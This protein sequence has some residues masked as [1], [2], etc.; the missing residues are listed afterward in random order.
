MR[1]KTE[2]LSFPTDPLAAIRELQHLNSGASHAPDEDSSEPGSATAL[3]V[4]GATGSKPGS[5][6]AKLSSS[7]RRGPAAGTAGASPADQ[8]AE[9]NPM[10]QAVLDM[11]ARPYGPEALKG[12]YTVTT[13]KIPTDIWDRLGMVCIL[14]GQTK[15]DIIAMALRDHFARLLEQY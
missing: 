12:P 1:K 11:L 13:M 15:Q 4:A 5:K 9:A 10:H 14:T 6:V 2:S 8:A 3:P 7:R